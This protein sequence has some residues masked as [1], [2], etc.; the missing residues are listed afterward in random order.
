MLIWSIMCLCGTA[1]VLCAHL[2]GLRVQSSI[3]KQQG[4]IC[5]ILA[6][7]MQTPRAQ[8][9]ATEFQAIHCV[10]IQEKKPGEKCI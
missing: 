7:V 2:M 6:K 3:S 10:Q 9:G 5:N 4:I 1:A 8:T